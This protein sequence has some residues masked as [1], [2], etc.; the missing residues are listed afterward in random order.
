MVYIKYIVYFY[1]PLPNRIVTQNNHDVL[2]NPQMTLTLF[3]TQI[4]LVRSLISLY[5]FSCLSSALRLERSK[6]AAPDQSHLRPNAIW[7]ETENTSGDTRWWQWRWRKIL[8]TLNNKSL[9]LSKF[10]I[11]SYCT[12]V[13]YE[14]KRKTQ[15]EI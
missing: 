15:L 6:G 9:F 3:S 4:T 13:R 10:W 11:K 7:T 8:S 1:S 14:R 5:F 2:F 12:Q